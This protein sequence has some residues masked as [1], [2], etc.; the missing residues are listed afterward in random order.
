MAGPKELP[1]RVIGGRNLHPFWERFRRLQRQS[2]RV[3]GRPVSPKGVFA[4]KS[5]EEFEKYR[6]QGV[7]SLKSPH[8]K[9]D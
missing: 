4:F 8:D 3:L 7:E 9:I 5:F 1:M 6:L 2:H